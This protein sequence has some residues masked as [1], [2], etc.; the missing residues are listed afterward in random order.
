MPTILSFKSP[1]EN[2]F[3][4]LQEI[5]KEKEIM[6][7]SSASLYEGHIKELLEMNRIFSYDYDSPIEDS[8]AKVS[9]PESENSLKQLFELLTNLKKSKLVISN[10]L[11]NLGD[12][13]ISQFVVALDIVRSTSFVKSALV[14]MENIKYTKENIFL[15][16]KPK[17]NCKKTYEF[18]DELWR[19]R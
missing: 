17:I 6:F 7:F 5:I 18:W 9:F 12:S 10:M 2:K 15:L 14:G 16:N 3:L 11:S 13:S 8:P 1:I 4:T 19:N